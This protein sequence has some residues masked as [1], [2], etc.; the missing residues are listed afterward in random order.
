M[1]ITKTFNHEGEIPFEITPEQ[2]VDYLEHHGYYEKGTI[3]SIFERNVEISLKTPW[4]FYDFKPD[5]L[6]S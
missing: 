6:T 1:R 4:A 3:E 5:P 2:A